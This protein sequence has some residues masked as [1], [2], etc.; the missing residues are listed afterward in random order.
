MEAVFA[1]VRQLSLCKKLLSKPFAKRVLAMSLGKGG[2]R[3]FSKPYIDPGLIFVALSAN[4][5]QVI[6]LGQYEVISS[7]QAVDYK[8][9]HQNR[10]LVKGLLKVAP[11]GEIHPQ[12]LKRAILQLLQQD[13]GINLSKQTGAIFCNLKQERLTTLM[14]HIRRVAREGD[15]S[16][17]AAK[18]TSSEFS[19]LKE[20]LNMVEVKAP[21]PPLKK[22]KPMLALEDKKPDPEEEA[23][24]EDTPLKKAEEVS[25]DS[26]GYPTM[27]GTP[28]KASKGTENLVGPSFLRR[29]LG[30][31]AAASTCQADK[32]DL[33]KSLGYSGSSKTLK[34]EKA[35]K[36]PA[37]AKA[38][39]DP[40]KKE[41]SKQP[42]LKKDPGNKRV[43]WVKLRKTVAKKP[44][45]AYI[46]GAHDTGNK[47]HLVVEVSEKMTPNFE[48][49]I[50]RIYL[51]LKKDHLTKQEAKDMRAALLGWN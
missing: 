34:K 42:S 38:K 11:S 50:D 24:E 29:R 7:S 15:W 28:D 19:Q 30:S 10:D 8:G 23:L 48:N 31:Q 33:K 49:I 6:D 35:L 39:K 43:P 9:L 40:L 44:A 45:R 4:K 25:L 3:H 13:P 21:E 51:A 18:L 16:M 20:V 27:F 47:V 26:S 32:K 46:C 5:E 17:A 36:K 14:S 12:A 2:P 1:Q 22:E 41:V 37:A